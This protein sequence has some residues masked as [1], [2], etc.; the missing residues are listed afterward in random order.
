MPSPWAAALSAATR[1]ARVQVLLAR[2]EMPNA[3]VAAELVHGGGH[4]E[5]RWYPLEKAASVPG[6]VAVRHRKD[7]WIILGAANFTRRGLKDLDL[8]AS[9]E[10][11]MPARA[12]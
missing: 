12:C 9:V 3:V 1:G 5:V 4:V 7:A 10:M 8:E 11:R 2:N 6:L